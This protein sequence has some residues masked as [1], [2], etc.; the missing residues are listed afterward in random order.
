ML[1]GTGSTGMLLKRDLPEEFVLAVQA[2]SDRLVSEEE[3]KE[4]VAWIKT[5][6]YVHPGQR[7]PNEPDYFDI[8]FAPARGFVYVYQYRQLPPHEHSTWAKTAKLVSEKTG[9]NTRLGHWYDIRVDVR[10]EGFDVFL[11]GE[12][13][14]S[15]PTSDPAFRRGAIGLLGGESGAVAHFKELVVRSR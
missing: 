1:L 2:K 13:V 8:C 5:Q 9:L 7:G 6:L 10:K 4:H 15:V 14:A 11:D 12:E 3:F